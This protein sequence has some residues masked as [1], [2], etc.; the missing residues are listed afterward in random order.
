[1]ILVAGLSFC[2]RQRFAAYAVHSLQGQKVWRANLRYRTVENRG[3]ARPL[4]EFPRNLRR[5]LGIRLLVHHLQR[6]L[7]LL[8]RDNA[9]EG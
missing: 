6:L 3:A 2:A 9:Q 5:E 7:Y 4:A 8:F 1:M